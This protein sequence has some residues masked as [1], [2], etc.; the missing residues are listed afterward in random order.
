MATYH[1]IGDEPR[2]VEAGDGRL[3]FV[4]SDEY[5]AFGISG[6][7]VFAVEGGT[8]GR[9]SGQLPDSDGSALSDGEWS[10][11]VRMLPAWVEF[12]LFGRDEPD[13]HCRIEL[14]DS[15][16]N[17]VELSYRSSEKQREIRQKHLRA[18]ELTELVNS[19]YRQWIIE[20]RDVWRDEPGGIGIPAIGEEQQ[21]VL[22]NLVYDM[23]A[24]RRQVNAELLQQ[25]AQVYRD[26]FD[27]APAEAVARTFGVKPRMAHQYIRRAR[28]HGFLPPTT[29]GKKKI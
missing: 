27:H 23:K 10:P 14:R 29:Q 17:L 4:I 11:S 26:H 28:E 22:R 19:V 3:R 15:V 20:V 12:D 24:G 2:T 1:R 13:L 25:V 16:P 7:P 9:I 21:R 6:E 5:M 18:T 8:P